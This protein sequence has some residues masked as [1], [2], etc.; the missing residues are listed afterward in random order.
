MPRNRYRKATRLIR[1]NLSAK[2][3]L[4]LG[5]VPRPLGEH[6]ESDLGRD[7]A[8]PHGAGDSLW[9]THCPR[10]PPREA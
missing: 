2:G 7:R 10:A 8:F 5:A 1:R 9:D 6:W 3:L 4:G